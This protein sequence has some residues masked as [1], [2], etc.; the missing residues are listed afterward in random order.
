MSCS[1]L[2]SHYPN[3]LSNCQFQQAHWPTHMS[4][5]AQNQSNQDDEGNNDQNEAAAGHEAVQHFLSSSSNNAA[6]S[7]SNGL[8]S[9]PSRSLQQVNQ[10]DLN[11]PGTVQKFQDFLPLRFYVKS[12]GHFAA[13]E[14]RHFDFFSSYEV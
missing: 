14:N 1:C 3:Y 12:I 9:Q 2:C 4:T 7:R 11:H 5:C 6:N 13:P 10:F 8:G